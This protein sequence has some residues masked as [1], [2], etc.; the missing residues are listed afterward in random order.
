MNI[1]NNIMG[2]SQDSP[3]R[4]FAE[5]DGDIDKLFNMGKEGDM[6][7]L[8][9]RNIVNFPGVLAS[10]TIAR[11]TTRQLVKYIEKHPKQQFAMFCQKDISIEEPSAEDLCEYGVI[12]QFLKVFEMPGQLNRYA[13]I[14]QGLT[15]CRIESVV[16][17]EP[18]LRAHVV[19]VPEEKPQENDMELTYSKFF[20]MH[21]FPETFLDYNYNKPMFVL[22]RKG[23]HISPIFNFFEC[24]TRSAP[25]PEGLRFSGR[26]IKAECKLYNNGVAEFF[27]PLGKKLHIGMRGEKD[28]GRFPYEWFWQSIYNSVL[29]YVDIVNPILRFQRFFV[30]ISVVGCKDVIVETDFMADWESRI[31]RDILLCYPNAFEVNENGKINDEDMSVFHLDYLTSLG[32][33]YDK[34]IQIIIDKLYGEHDREL[35][36]SIN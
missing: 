23:T 24:D 4:M 9:T 7:V 2:D 3:M 30:C 22:E 18:F 29:S 35:G 8:I 28:K 20:I 21:I 1:I 19:P 31:D 13:F 5:F 16:K 11:D 15:R 33:K 32:V 34:T 25:T 6:P 12:S 17:E 27:Y 14:A 10:V 26:G 36:E